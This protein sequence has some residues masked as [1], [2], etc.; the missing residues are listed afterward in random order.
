MFN[1][2]TLSGFETKLSELTNPPNEVEVEAKFGFYRNKKFTSEVTF[3]HFNS[4]KNM[5]SDSGLP[6]TIEHTKDYRSKSGIR[7]QVISVE[8]E[9]DRVV[10]QRKSRLHDFDEITNKYG[11]RVSLNSEKTIES[12][13]GFTY[14]VLRIR[15]RESFNRGGDIRID[16]T[17]IDF[18]STESRKRGGIERCSYQN[19]YEVEVEII[20]WHENITEKLKEFNKVLKTVFKTLY[21]TENLYTTEERGAL[22]SFMNR[23]LG[24]DIKRPVLDFGMVAQA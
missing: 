7:K 24:E 18:Q 10:W 22:F 8:G 19:K 4:L 15:H 23:R 11:V 14:D 17:E 20:N 5:L 2:E 21:D 9:E 12:V 13:D 1:A 6:S 3:K 16:M